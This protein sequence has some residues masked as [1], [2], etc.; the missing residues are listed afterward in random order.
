MKFLGGAPTEK[1][2][3]PVSCP[4]NIFLSF[5]LNVDSSAANEITLFGK[6]KIIF[7]KVFVQIAIAVEENQVFTCRNGGGIV[8]DHW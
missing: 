2:D 8:S 1:R 5:C 7:D 4:E 6:R 3:P